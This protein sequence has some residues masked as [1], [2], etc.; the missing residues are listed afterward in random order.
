MHLG[1]I[2]I[3]DAKIEEKDQ[4]LLNDPT[5]LNRTLEALTIVCGLTKVNECIHKFEPQGYTICH[6]LAE[7][8][9][10]IHTW[11]EESS[12]AMDIYS[13][14]HD[15][16]IEEIKTTLKQFFPNTILINTQKTHRCISI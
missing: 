16:D 13:C 11:P 2:V 1:T 5:Y 3:I 14:K 10:S 12:F 15:L 6:V 7:S 8:H 9:I 4:S